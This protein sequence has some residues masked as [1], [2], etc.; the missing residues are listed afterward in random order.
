MITQ[1]IA[2][3][4]ITTY[5]LD[6]DDSTVTITRQGSII[7]TSTSAVVE[8]PS[9]SGNTFIVNGLLWSSDATALFSQG[10]GTTI[11]IGANGTLGGD[12]PLRVMGAD[13]D[14][15]VAGRVTSSSSNEAMVIQSDGATI[16]I[17]GVVSGLSGIGVYTAGNVT[18]TIGTDGIVDGRQMGVVFGNMPP[19]S[20]SHIFNNGLLEGSLAAFAGYVGIEYVTNK[21]V[22]NG[23][24]YL[25]GGNDVF[26]NRRGSVDGVIIGNEGDDTFIIDKSDT[27]LLEASGQGT[28]TVKSLASF[29]LGDHFENL[30][31]LGA[32]NINAIGNSSENTV[33]GNTGKNTLSGLE[34]A[35]SLFGGKGNDMLIGGSEGDTFVYK[36]ACGKDTIA[37]FELGVDALDLSA[38]KAATTLASLKSHAKEI[39]DD[40]SIR[41]GDDELV[42]RHLTKAELDHV[43]I[44]I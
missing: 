5:T 42:I 18:I 30:I 26:D 31:L 6:D 33:T 24:V 19:T 21:G 36:S 15:S 1:T 35:D 10:T 16:D 2:D 44:T 3:S 43:D 32:R 11:I 28:D 9:G 34:G 8:N 40:L 7:T 14:I 23:D 4:R 20:V 12:I 39:D 38:W 22:M 37:D 17:T 29:S 27:E 25:G 41:Y 13:V